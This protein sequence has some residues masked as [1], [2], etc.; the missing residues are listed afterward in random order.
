MRKVLLA[1]AALTAAV[2]ATPV[3]SGASSASIARSL[4]SGVRV[5]LH[6][7]T[8][9]VRFI[10]TV[11]GRPIARPAGL[12]A[13]ASPQAVAR[14]FLGAHGKLFGL[15]NQ[16]RDLRVLRTEHAAGGRSVVRFQQLFRGIPVVA[17]ELVV[18]LD[19]EGNILSAGGEAAPSPNV[20]VSAAISAAE[21][22]QIAERA[23][24]KAH[25]LRSKLHA[26]KPALWI[27]DRDLLDGPGPATERLVWRTEVKAAGRADIR[28]FVLVDARSGAV[29]V[30]FN[31]VADAKNR[32]ICDG[33]NVPRSDYTCGTAVPITR[34]EGQAAT[35]IADVDLAYQYAGIVYDFFK[36]RFNRDSIDNAGMPLKQTVR[37]CDPAGCPYENAFWDGNQMVYGTGFAS[38]DDVVAHEMTHGVTERTA[39]L[40]YW[41]QSGAI[42]E[43]ISDVMG[44]YVDLTDGVGTDTAAT[45]WLMGE[46]LPA[47]I[48]AIRDMED[49]PAFGD[50][51][52]MTSPNY[53]GSDL[54]DNGGVHTNSGVNNKAAFLIADGGT[55]NGKTITGLGISKAAKIYYELIA[56]QLTSGSDYQ[57]VFFDL[58]QSC[59][60]LVGTVVDGSAITAANCQQVQNAV[61]A[62]EM[63]LQPTVNG[64][65]NFPAVPEAP[66]C[67]SGQVPSD[68]FFDNFENGAGKWVKQ[69]AVGSN[70]W[71][72][73]TP[74]Y[75]TSGTYAL[76]ADGS[77][78]TTSD[79]SV[80][81]ATALTIPTGKTTYLR[82]SHA[83][84]FEA[85]SEYYDGGVLETSS[86]GGAWTD[87]GTK[88]VDNG[89][90]GPLSTSWGNPL[91]GRNAF[92]DTIGGFSSSRAD[93]SSLAGQAVKIRFR[94]G[95]DDSNFAYFDGWTIDNVRI[96]NCVAGPRPAGSASTN[97][98]RNAGMEWDDN[99][100]GLPDFWSQNSGA[101]RM[102][103]PAPLHAGK[104]SL[105]LGRMATVGEQAYTI[106]QQVP[107]TAG[108]HYS[109]SGW[110]NIPGT[111]SGVN[112]KFQIVW[113]NS[114]GARLST[115]TVKS[116][117]AHP[118]GWNQA[119]ASPLTAPTGTV[120]ARVAL[121]QGNPNVPVFV[122]DVNFHNV[123]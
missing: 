46:D 71:T 123:P 90:V 25:D 108:L 49:P 70:I 13:S 65:G 99:D 77:R 80:A 22:V 19:A 26:A 15:A 118:T 53:Y 117:T 41:M 94:A 72:I 1:V 64:A 102:P 17:G 93:L 96:Y 31:Q 75:S 18:N 40:F 52:K 16:A 48:G 6:S 51:D 35:G 112:A 95:T 7:E 87:A 12:A 119:L 38:A 47:S 66:M 36:T 33:A 73:N 14:A 116:Y 27:Y 81:K 86:N 9:Q 59:Q 58:P 56:N 54:G 23:T 21:A 74:G 55:F 50:P 85:G 24:A 45:R 106:A 4:G 10:G 76:W 98:V 62:T 3:A 114:S 105:K 2:I 113:L 68:L 100:N 69:T 11:A 104:Y 8:G 42:N 107:V 109:A 34:S 61:A 5:G 32:Q 60:N 37:F 44:E 30:T 91:G 79:S 103:T 57:D 88:L 39:N 78:G 110:F 97:L 89:Y 101:L 28:Q 84:N 20:E 83:L 115:S 67:P 43:S 82:F 92:T 122:D 121:V 63:N 120:A 29:V 111:A